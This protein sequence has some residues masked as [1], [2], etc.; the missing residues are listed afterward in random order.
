MNKKEVREKMLSLLSCIDEEVRREQ[1]ESIADKVKK[2]PEL[3]NAE[4]IFAYIGTGYEIETRE[5]VANMLDDGKRVC[6]PLCYG[7]GE[8]DAIEIK[9]LSELSP[10]RY[11][12]PEPPNNGEKVNPKDISAIIV[13]GVAFDKKGNRLGRGGGY[14][15]RFMQKTENAVK[16]AL[17]REINL[18]DKVPCE[19]HDQTVDIIATEKRVIRRS[20]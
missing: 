20:V 8:M 13:P 2:M 1:D 4:C 18:I 9:S 14:Y 11:G 10:G 16:V 3:C 12:I 6:V 17:C 7:K 19:E 15:D 5:I